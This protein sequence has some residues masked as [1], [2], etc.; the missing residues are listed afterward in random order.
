ME[1]PEM[2][3]IN[4]QPYTELDT[5]GSS[6]LKKIYLSEEM[7]GSQ[8]DE[9]GKPIDFAPYLIAVFKN[10]KAVAYTPRVWSK[11]QWQRLED[12]VQQLVFESESL[13]GSVGKLFTSTIKNAAMEADSE[14]EEGKWLTFRYVNLENE[15]DG[16]YVTEAASTP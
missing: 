10:G 14:P 5:A 8:V 11:D 15:A 4:L 13:E 6:L 1:Q 12:E 16:K 7:Y 3:T 9:G 2:L